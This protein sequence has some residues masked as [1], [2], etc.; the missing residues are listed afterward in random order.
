MGKPEEILNKS[1][2]ELPRGGHVLEAGNA[3]TYET[4][5]WTTFYPE[6]HLDICIQCLLCWVACPDSAILT[7]GEKITGFDLFHCKGCGI[8]SELCPTKPTKAITM[9]KKEM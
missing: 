6:L 7:E 8:C 9:E 3:H 4:G 1:W 2:R 5:T